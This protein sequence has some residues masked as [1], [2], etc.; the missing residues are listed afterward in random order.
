MLSMSE[1]TVEPDTWWMRG[2]GV[3]VVLE[4]RWCRL[5]MAERYASCL[6]SWVVLNSVKVV[7]RPAM[8]SMSCW[9]VGWFWITG[10]FLGGMGRSNESTK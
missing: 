3:G 4:M 10:S 7:V 9:V 5:S 8:A 2:V 1:C 6:R